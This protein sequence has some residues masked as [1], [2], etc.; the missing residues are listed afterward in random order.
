MQS[1]RSSAIDAFSLHGHRARNDIARGGL[2]R[3]DPL[4][5]PQLVRSLAARWAWARAD[6][7]P[8]SRGTVTGVS[9]VDPTQHPPPRNPQATRACRRLRHAVLPKLDEYLQYLTD[10]LGLYEANRPGGFSFSIVDVNSEERR[11]AAT[12]AA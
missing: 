8:A 2:G 6:I 12:E 4:C 3:G 1:V 10:L 7:C 9:G 5:G 11:R